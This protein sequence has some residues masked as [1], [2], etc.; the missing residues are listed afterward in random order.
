ME[1][2]PATVSPLGLAGR[3]G[4]GVSHRSEVVATGDIKVRVKGLSGT[5]TRMGSP[6]RGVTV[7]TRRPC[8]I[9]MWVSSRTVSTVPCLRLFVRVSLFQSVGR[10][11]P[12]SRIHG[13]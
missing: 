7:G 3:P 5:S 12:R 6:S 9:R 1:T 13:L 10:D 4:L 2:T 8:R 11:G